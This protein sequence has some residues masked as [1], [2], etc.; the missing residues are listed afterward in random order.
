MFNDAFDDLRYRLRALVRRQSVETDLRDELDAHVAHVAQ[1]FL[2]RG[3]SRAEAERR[4]RIALGGVEPVKEACRDAR[5]VSLVETA[6]QD[7]RYAARALAA[8]PAFTLAAVSTLALG[9]G[10]NAA[11]FTAVRSVLL[12]PLP[13]REPERLVRIWPDRTISNA[14]LLAFQSRLRSFEQVAAFSPG[15]GVY[16]SGPG[17]PSHLEGARVSTNFFATLGVAP[18]LGRDFRPGESSAGAW[19]AVI[20]S[21]EI[22]RTHYG[23]DRSVVGRTVNIDGTPHVIIG[24]MARGF[25]AFH[26]QVDVWLPLQIDPSS[27][28]HTGQTSYGV[29]RLRGGVTGT[30]AAME[31]ASI[32]PSI[33][34]QFGFTDDYGRSSTVI[35]LRES[36]AGSARRPLLAL[37]GAATLIVLIAGANFG[38]L[39]L[40]RGAS[41]HREIVVRSA[42]GASR[43]RVIRLLLSESV[44][45]SSA[46]AAVGLVA[47]VAATRLVPFI[48]PAAF[49]RRGEIGVDV[50]VVIVVVTIALVVGVLFGL[51]PA[52]LAGRADPQGALRSGR[53]GD[54]GTRSGTQLRS[55]LIV[56][57]VALALVLSVGAGLMLRTVWRLYAVDVGFRADHVLTV[58]LEPDRARVRDPNQR[59]AY[60]GDMLRRIGD[61]P[62]VVG[63]G[64]SHHLPLSGFNWSG[65]V[66]IEREPQP[67]TANL[68]RAVWRV[69]VGDYF[70][71]MGIPLLRGRVFDARDTRDAPPVVIISEAMARHR[72]PNRDPLGE[73]IRVGNAT[74]DEWATIIGIVGDVHSGA[75]DT[76]AGDEMYRSIFQQPQ[77]FTHLV[78]R[79][80]GD[81]LVAL[82]AVRAAIRRV[83]AAAA[84]SEA[85]SLDQLVER[86]IAERRAVM[87]LLVVF[88][89]VGAMLGVIG[90]HGIVA[91]AVTQRTRELGIRSALGAGQRAVLTMMVGHGMRLALWG[92]ALGVVGSIAASRSLSALLFG[93]SSSDPATYVALGGAMLVVMLVA[94]YLPARR[95]LRIDPVIALRME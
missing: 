27:P 57:E 21:D 73:R 46:G 28:Y 50:G 53:G 17:E 10:L 30:R 52:L 13:Y 24:V 25:A 56:G 58:R 1:Q 88:A 91:F 31:L 4:A 40:L 5:G 90:V 14:E 81:P 83:D 60:Y 59:P 16:S 92:I 78:V 19:N 85:A 67:P 33:R 62:G 32:A 35:D 69:V 43:G 51:A 22:W 18:A 84:I 82:P 64:G 86:S 37:F 29:G 70:R 34:A 36:I 15:W 20:L 8:R 41:R 87:Q 68:P 12:R 89:M 26:S 77:V 79:T 2:A 48:L 44:L 76:P 7:L 47:A 66:E 93:V 3:L 94:S 6:L 11:V 95:A 74:R 71:T 63:V 23:R 61:I 42:L 80:R 75:L 65:R 38:T 55:L 72:W 54:G 45:L 9:L 39:L 49:P